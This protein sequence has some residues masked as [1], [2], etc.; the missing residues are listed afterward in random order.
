MY[1]FFGKPLLL[2]SRCWPIQSLYVT[3]APEAESYPS[4]ATRLYVKRPLQRQKSGRARIVAP[5]MTEGAEKSAMKIGLGS[6]GADSLMGRSP[7]KE[8]TAALLGAEV[9]IAAPV[10]DMESKTGVH[11]HAADW[12]FYHLL[13]LG[14]PG[15]S[16]GAILVS[17]PLAAKQH[18]QDDPDHENRGDK[19]QETPE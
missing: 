11:V 17:K 13:R 6:L 1:H 8:L 3:Y 16:L 18:G 14:P 7:G 9:V 10:F 4:R 19:N 12:V 5:R 2:L 15:L